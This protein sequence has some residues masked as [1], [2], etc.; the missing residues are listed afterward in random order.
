MMIFGFSLFLIFIVT[1]SALKGKADAD[2]K[3][4]DPWGLVDGQS[5]FLGPNLWDRDV[6][7][8]SD[9]KVSTTI[10]A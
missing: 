6:F 8:D 7:A 3:D 9:L 4:D 1:F 5:A 2:K 10:S